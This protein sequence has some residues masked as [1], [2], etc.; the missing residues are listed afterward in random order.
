MSEEK[1]KVRS[2][3]WRVCRFYAQYLDNKYPGEFP[4]HDPGNAE[5]CLRN[6]NV[7]L[8]KKHTFT[9]SH[10]QE[11]NDLEIMAGY[12]ILPEEAFSWLKNNERAT[13]YLWAVI[14]LD[15]QNHTPFITPEQDKNRIRKHSWRDGLPKVNTYKALY[16]IDS[17]STH[18]ERLRIIKEYF[19]GAHSLNQKG[20]KIAHMENLKQQWLDNNHRAQQFTWLNPDDEEMCHWFWSRIKDKQV[21][22]PGEKKTVTQFFIPSSV[23]DYYLAS[24]TAYDLWQAPEDSRELF[25]SRINHSWHQQKQKEKYRKDDKKAINTY[26]RKDVKDMLDNI[27]T[28]YNLRMSDVLEML[29]TE[30]Y[31][32]M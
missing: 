26:V 18:H 28:E 2:K 6:I 3:D 1:V 11:V 21:D 22:T 23:R 12:A 31:H 5:N 4:E 25:K 8:E 16:L 29:I 15:T 19:D 7:F 27:V 24:L 10:N 9:F 17:P 20:A 13:F 30:K 32:S 14:Y